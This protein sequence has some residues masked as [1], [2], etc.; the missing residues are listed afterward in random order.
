[1][2]LADF[3]RAKQALTEIQTERAEIDW[4]KVDVTDSLETQPP[5]EESTTTAANWA[6][7]IL[8]FWLVLWLLGLAVCF[9]AW[10]FTRNAQLLVRLI[11]GILIITL[12][13]G[14]PLL[15]FRRR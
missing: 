13:L 9:V 8:R 6:V 2:K 11:A 4:S 5:V 12:A 1:M 15:A 7:N 10:L 14:L 3:D